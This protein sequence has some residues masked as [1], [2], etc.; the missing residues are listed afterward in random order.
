MAFR[1]ATVNRT[2]C[3]PPRQLRAVSTCS[4]NMR[5]AIWNSEF[6]IGNSYA[7][8]NVA[9]MLLHRF[10]SQIRTHSKFQIPNSKLSRFLALL[11]F[12]E[13]SEFQKHVLSVHR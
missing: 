7:S 10:D 5:T 12:P 1:P 13:L 11:Q 8:F 3:C 2:W 4:E 9:D 6:G